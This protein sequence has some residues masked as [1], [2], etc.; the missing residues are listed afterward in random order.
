MKGKKND[1]E[2]VSEFITLCIN[3]GI[4]SSEDILKKAVIKINNIDSKIKE[5][6]KL[7]ILRSKLLDVVSTFE[8]PQVS[9]K[10]DEIKILS[11]FKIQNPHIC[12]LICDIVKNK[13]SKLESFYNKNFPPQDIIFCVKQLL[14]A[15]IIVKTGDYFICGNMY[16][17]YIKFILKG[18]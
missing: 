9:K 11:F 1:S 10:N 17:D 5:V 8:K 6:E 4:N 2:F 14:D 7:K 16:N 3:E 18:E 15:K 13:S 12:K